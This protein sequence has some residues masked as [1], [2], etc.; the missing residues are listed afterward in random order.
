MRITS[1]RA[2]EKFAKMVEFAK[3]AG[4]D[5]SGWRFGQLYGHLYRLEKPHSEYPN[6]HTNVGEFVTPREAW[7]YMDAMIT[8]FYVVQR[9]N[10]SKPML[11]LV[12]A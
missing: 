12:A 11:E 1:K 10:E 3:D 4:V 6:M 8:A 5:M 9:S 7:N 2:H